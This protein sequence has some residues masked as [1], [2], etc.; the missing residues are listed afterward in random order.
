MGVSLFI[1]LV[2]VLD[3]DETL[4]Q[5]RKWS[6]NWLLQRGT[7]RHATHLKEL[8]ISE[9]EDFRNFLQMDAQSSDEL[10]GLVELLMRKKD[11]VTRSSI[12]PS[13]RLSITLRGHRASVWFLLLCNRCTDRE[14]SV[15]RRGRG[16]E[17]CSLNLSSSTELGT[18]RQ[19]QLIVFAL[20]AKE[21]TCCDLETK[22]SSAPEH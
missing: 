18:K 5:R 16:L 19:N 8:R 6:K 17:H 21:A 12:S 9:P 10:L 15:R 11:T 1:A 3:S 13:E 7:Y 20:T 14:I 22:S 4:C 2:I